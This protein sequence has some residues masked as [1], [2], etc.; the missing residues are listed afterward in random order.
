[1]A[2]GTLVVKER[3]TLSPGALGLDPAI[4]S[5]A[6]DD[7][8]RPLPD[9]RRLTGGDQTLLRDYFQR[10]GTLTPSAAEALAGQLAG[11]LAARLGYQLG[12]ESPERFLLRLGAA[13]ARPAS[14]S[15]PFA[16]RR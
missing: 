16:D 11:A 4:A 2:A 8:E 13:L 12:G 10:R 3:R 9:L 14:P 6:P 5:A 7:G 1:M 15:A